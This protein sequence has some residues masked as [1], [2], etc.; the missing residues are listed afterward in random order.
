VIKAHVEINVFDVSL[1]IEREMKTRGIEVTGF[2]IKS[3]NTE[4]CTVTGMTPNH[5]GTMEEPVRHHLDPKHGNLFPL[6]D[7]NFTKT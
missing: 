4:V 6:S 7:A 3:W 1:L 2:T 5:A